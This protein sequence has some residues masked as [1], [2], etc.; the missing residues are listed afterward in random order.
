[1]S[2]IVANG[3]TAVPLDP[4]KLFGGKPY[5]TVPAPLDPCDVVW[6][7]DD[8]LVAE[9]QAYAKKHL[10]Q[11]MYNHSM[12][13]YYFATT[14]LQQQFPEYATGLSPSTL[15]LACLLHD[16]GATEANM[17]ATRMSFDLYGGVRAL[18]V[19][20]SAGAAPDQAAAVC[21]CVL[22]HQDLG[23]EGAITLLGQL[24]QLATAV[25]RLFPRR[26]W[27]GCFARVVETETAL[28][29]WCHTTAIP[30][31]ADT[32][33]ANELMRPYE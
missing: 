18:S 26:G 6:P 32:I 16:L 4:S 28:K 5:R 30:G 27:L 25:V 2:D 14:I 15:A 3:W 31:F 1:M 29:P 10:S 23:A 17:R 24:V 9:M 22:R 12:R 7:S 11:E 8:P 33:R 21:E 13:V 20:E 19:L